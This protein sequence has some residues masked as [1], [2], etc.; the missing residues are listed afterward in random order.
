MAENEIDITEQDDGNFTYDVGLSIPEWADKDLIRE[1]AKAQLGLPF[2]L[3]DQLVATITKQRIVKIKSDAPRAEADAEAAI[4]QAVGFRAE[5]THSLA[6]KKLAPLPS[7]SKIYCPA[8]D[9]KVE[10]LLDSQCPNCKV[11]VNRLNPQALQQI[12]ERRQEAA[13]V[14]LLV[15]AQQAGEY[16]P[17]PKK[18]WPKTPL[19]IIA[20]IVLTGAYFDRKH[21]LQTVGLTKPPAAAQIAATAE[22]DD[23]IQKTLRQTFQLQLDLKQAD[24]STSAESNPN[25]LKFEVKK[26]EL[27]GDGAPTAAGNPIIGGSYA[28]N[29]V[30]TTNHPSGNSSS[31]SS[32]A[33]ANNEA[34]NSAAPAQPAATAPAQ[35]SASSAAANESLSLKANLSA[36]AKQELSNELIVMLAEVGQVDRGRD[37]LDKSRSKADAKWQNE[38]AVAQIKLEAWAIV[39]AKSN[40]GLAPIED[41][42]QLASK[43]PDAASR[44]IASAHA[45]AI[46]LYRADLNQDAVS[47]LF[48]LAGQAYAAQK[49]K[50]RSSEVGHEVLVMRGRAIFNNALAKLGRGERQLAVVMAGQLDTMTRIAPEASAAV[51]HGFSQQLAR[52]M[53]NAEGANLGL[54]MALEKAHGSESLAQEGS[55]LRTLADFDGVYAELKMQ[56]ALASLATAAEEKGGVDYAATLVEIALTHARNGNLAQMQE[57]QNKLQDLASSKPQLAVQAERLVGLVNIASAW[58][59]KRNGNFKLAERHLQQ[60]QE[61]VK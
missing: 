49:G 44:A 21:L 47:E 61:M 56:A 59:A 36:A 20:A 42:Y 5:V 6:L 25:A 57:T 27:P 52:I 40:R 32:N 13:R 24:T 41:L 29:P 15:K 28:G 39:Y 14:E 55:S 51:L 50:A 1:R 10:L 45:A 19:F 60:A 9:A 53:G 7:D 58:Q 48:S 4:Y 3:I 11:F 18:T 43:I 8:C 17:T 34:A 12:R 30:S 16:L 23:D 26:A 2:E 37:L 31:S 54:K 22:A 46:I 38:L 33:A 35:A